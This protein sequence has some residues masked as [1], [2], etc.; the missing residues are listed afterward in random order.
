MIS[1][2]IRMSEY[3]EAP[4]FLSDLLLKE[5]GSELTE[6]II[7]GYNT[8]RI[9]SFRVN[10]IKAS[11]SL[12]ESILDSLG[13][14]YQKYEA[15]PHAY[16]LR[17]N[18]ASDL[19]DSDLVKSGKIYFQS[20][21]SMLPPLFL[22]PLEGETILDMAAAPGGKTTMLAAMTNNKAEIT[23]CEVNKIRFERMKHNLLVQ[24]A[25]KVFPMREDAK[26]L[27]DFFSFDK[28]L[29]D[30]PCSGAGTL[31][32]N[33]PKDLKAFSYELIKNSA[34]LQE[35]LLKKALRILKPN[36]EMIYSTCS[37]LPIENEDN[38]NKILKQYNCKIIPIQ[39][40]NL[41]LLPSKIEGTI[42]VCPNEYYEGFFIAKIKKNK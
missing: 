34:K 26:R 25:T 13:I 3:V 38:V 39:M 32:F 42:L 4:K 24:G 14:S 6:K 40:D 19:Y 27:D 2:A 9:T 28:I 29:L 41:P 1:E 33:N 31:D 18:K 21:S 12:V 10:T 15:I 5:Y 11:D 36:H 35:E 22:N 23:A 20:L 30:A 17:N 8:K 7:K 37:I 16:L